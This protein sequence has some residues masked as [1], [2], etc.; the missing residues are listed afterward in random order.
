VHPYRQN[1]EEVGISQE[2]APQISLELNGYVHSGRN[3][4]ENHEISISRIFVPI[5]FHAARAEGLELVLNMKQLE[6]FG[7]S[8]RLQYAAWKTY[9][10]GPVSGGFAGDEP[11]VPGERIVPAFDQTHTG[12]AQLFYRSKWHGAWGG[13]ALRYGSGTII[14]GGDRLPQHFTADLAA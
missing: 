3:S 1:Y 7:I 14:E 5:N 6:R 8:G 10:S 13:S 9:F 4:F 11:L 2:L 12:T